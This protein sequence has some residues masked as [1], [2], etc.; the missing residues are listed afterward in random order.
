MHESLTQPVTALSGIGGQTAK[1]LEKLG[2]Y[3]VLDLV[4]HLPLRY[5]DRTRIVPIGSLLADQRALIC[6]TIEFTDIIT[7]GRGSF[8]CKISDGTG[9]INLRFFHYNAGLQ[10]RLEVGALLSCFGEVRFGFSGLE[11]VHPEYKKY[12]PEKIT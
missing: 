4:F 3:R 10:K 11:M 12:Q 1:R 7:S 9:F 6:G 8:I 2:V 5:E